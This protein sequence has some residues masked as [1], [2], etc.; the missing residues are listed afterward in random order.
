MSWLPG[1]QSAVPAADHAHA[2][3]AGRRAM[4]GPRSTRSPRKTALRPCGG[5]TVERPSVADRRSRACASSASSS[6]RQ[7]WTSPMMSNGPCSSRR[8][9]HSGGAVDLDGL[10]LL[11]RAQHRRRAG[12]PRA[13]GPCSERRE[14]RRWLRDDV[15]AEVAVGPVA[16]ALVADRLGHVEHDRRPASSVVLAGERDQRLARLRAARSW[17]RRRSAGRRV[18]R[19]PAMKC[20]TVEGVARSPPGRSRRRRRGRGRSRTRG[21]RSA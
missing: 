4:R 8:S 18:S 9:V 2:R 14:L 17:R 13:A 7:P 15:R 10:D 16:V 20:S 21:L 1:T 6:S 5:V 11:G 3:A 19:L 12:S